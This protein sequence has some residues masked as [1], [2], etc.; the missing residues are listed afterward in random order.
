MYTSSNNFTGFLVYIIVVPIILY[1]VIIIGTMMVLC[2]IQLW[3]ICVQQ[4]DWI[5]YLCYKFRR[6]RSYLQY[7]EIDV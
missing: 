5:C 4:C 3:H 1:F 2:I 6:E 7:C